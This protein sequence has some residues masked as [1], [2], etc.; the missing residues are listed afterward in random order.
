MVAVGH[1]PNL[2]LKSSINES[3]DVPLLNAATF[4]NICFIIPLPPL[5]AIGC[6]FSF[7]PAS[8]RSLGFHWV[9]YYYLPEA[10]GS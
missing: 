3:S 10:G 6:C 5:L 4:R 7:P 2:Y 8:R 9:A 1:P